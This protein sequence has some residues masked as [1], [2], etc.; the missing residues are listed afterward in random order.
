[1]VDMV[2]SCIYIKVFEKKNQGFGAAL[3]ISSD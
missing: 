3:E 2:I 1:M